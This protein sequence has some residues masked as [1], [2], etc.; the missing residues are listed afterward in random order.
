MAHRADPYGVRGLLYALGWFVA[1][2]AFVLLV[3][4]CALP[5][6]QL[7]NVAP[8]DSTRHGGGDWFMALAASA[9]IVL[10]LLPTLTPKRP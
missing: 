10:V 4:A 2:V 1:C 5:A 3:G 6:S 8:V 7:K 9:L